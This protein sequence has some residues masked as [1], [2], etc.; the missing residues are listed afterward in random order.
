MG[1][2]KSGPPQG[3][4]YADSPYRDVV[5]SFTTIADAEAFLSGRDP[6]EDDS[7]FYAVKNGRIPGIYSSW[8]EA[9]KQIKGWTK[10]KY[11]L[12]TTR[13]EAESFVRGEE[14]NGAKKDDKKAKVKAE[15][16]HDPDADPSLQLLSEAGLLN[17]AGK[18][19]RKKQKMSASGSG[20]TQSEKSSQQ[21]RLSDND[22]LFVSSMGALASDEED[23]FSPTITSSNFATKRGGKPK[24]RTQTKLLQIKGSKSEGILRIYTDGSSLGN[25]KGGAVAGVGV[26]F[27][28]GDVR[29]V[30]QSVWV[31]R[32]L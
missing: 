10:P 31:V 32:S 20:A 30:H 24:S 15:E 6:T 11:R 26:F 3:R 28:V 21:S 22:E 9:Q 8:T 17:D 5:K 25:G 16:F 12:F 1:D 4:L 27:G 2:I 7:K 23:T 13:A 18:A 19:P 29:Y 14:G